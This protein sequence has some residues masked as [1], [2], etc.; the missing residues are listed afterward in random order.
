MRLARQADS[1]GSHL[2]SDWKLN[3]GHGRSGGHPR[4]RWSDQI[5]NFAGGGWMTVAA[6]PDQWDLAEDLFATYASA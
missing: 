5:E 1:K 6:H 2:V 4:T 3:L